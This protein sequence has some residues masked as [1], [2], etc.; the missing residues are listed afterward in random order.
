MLISCDTN[1]YMDAA[2]IL[3]AAHFCSG[4]ESCGFL[5]TTGGGTEEMTPTLHTSRHRVDTFLVMSPPCCGPYGRASGPGAWCTRRWSG[6]SNSWSAS[7]DPASSTPWGK[8]K[9]P[10]QV[11]IET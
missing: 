5:R 4:W 7:S 11:E 9:C 8:R 6:P 1:I 3:A 10:P 2:A